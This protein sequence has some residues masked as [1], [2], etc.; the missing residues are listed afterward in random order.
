MKSVMVLPL[1]LEL[2]RSGLVQQPTNPPKKLSAIEQQQ[3]ATPQ[4]PARPRDEDVVRISTNLVQVDAVVTDKNGKQVI[5]LRP[6]ELEILEDGKPQRVTSFSYISLDSTESP[7]PAESARP[8]DKNVFPVPPVR[9]RPEQIRRTM[10]LVV[11]DLGL[12]FESA[13]YVRQALKKFLDQ[14]MQPAD[15]VAIVRTGGGMGALQVFTSDKRQLYAAVEK[16]KW[17][18]TGRGGIAT[19]AP[20]AADPLGR[21]S[22]AK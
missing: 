17:N 5:D 16:V 3:L 7:R 13:Y 14:Q 21:D 18:P 19:F 9:L 10:A 6:E 8:V 11:D 4:Q 15:L 1:V 2:A 20:L 12:S 22:V